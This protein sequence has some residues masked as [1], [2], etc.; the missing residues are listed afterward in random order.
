MKAAYA[1]K[2]LCDILCSLCRKDYLTLRYTSVKRTLVFYNAVIP[3]T[4]TKN[5]HS[6]KTF[7]SVKDKL[8]SLK[9]TIKPSENTMHKF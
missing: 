4:L 3:N 8:G 5:L 1:K 7:S 9:K 2:L 6:S